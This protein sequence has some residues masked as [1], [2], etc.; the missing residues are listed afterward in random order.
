MKQKKKK[1]V[2]SKLVYGV[3]LLRMDQVC[4]IIIKAE[5]VNLGS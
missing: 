4:N 1:G 2:K 3:I 5:I